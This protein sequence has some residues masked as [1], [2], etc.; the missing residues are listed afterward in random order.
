[1]LRKPCSS[2]ASGGSQRTGPDLSNVGQRQ[3]SDVWQLLH[4]YNPRTVV[5]DSV[6]P[7]F[8]W[9]F[10]VKETAAKEDVMVPIPPSHA[11]E[12]GVVVAKQKALDLTAYLLSLEQLPIDGTAEA[13]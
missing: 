5:P 11:P 10:E 6:M 3:S 1:M 13:P 8:P 9:L 2:L 7:A 12:G 4:L